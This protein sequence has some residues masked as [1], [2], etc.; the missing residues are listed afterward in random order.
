LT[1]TPLSKLG[2][3]RMRALL[4]LTMLSL[5]V[6]G[7]DTREP[8]AATALLTAAS[9]KPLG[10]APEIRTAGARERRASALALRLAE[11]DGAVRRWRRAS[12]LR[13]AHAAA[14][15]ALNLVVGPAG[16]YYGDADRDGAVAGASSIGLLPGL[17][18]EAGLAQAADG[19]CVV[20]DILGGGWE[21]PARRWSFLEA[22]IGAWSP[23]RN[24][25]P[26]LPSHPQRVV[27]WAA[28][29]LTSRNLMTA[30]D[31]GKHAQLHIDVSRAAL[32][33]C[34]P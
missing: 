20:R 23:F 21:Q 3:F 18:G 29:T 32:V 33:A 31:Y 7:C 26:S 6:P 34:K 8:V 16:P 15:E 24:T 25:F 22:A 4:S 10:R 19:A 5:A 27:G 1:K 14:E 11:I 17:A 28:L 2:L 13:V 12:H 30:S 9:K